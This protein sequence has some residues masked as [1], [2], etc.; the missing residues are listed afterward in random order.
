MAE[1][2]GNGADTPPAGPKFSVLAQY[3]KAFSFKIPYDPAPWARSKRPPTSQYRSMSTRGSSPLPTTRSAL[4]RGRRWPGRRH[5]VQVRA[6]LCGRIPGGELS[7][8]Q[9]QPVVMIEGPRILFRSRGKS[10]RTRCVAGH[11]RRSLST[12]SIFRR[13]ICRDERRPVVNCSNRPPDPSPPRSH[14]G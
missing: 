10:L 1:Q 12:R 4:S 3:P 5:D 8:E 2:N 11:I 9:V 6:Q 7:A 13:F 14:A